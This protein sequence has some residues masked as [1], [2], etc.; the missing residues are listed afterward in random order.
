M[1][2]SNWAHSIFC[3]YPAVGFAFY[4][5]ISLVP[6]V[7]LAPALLDWGTALAPSAMANIFSWLI[8]LVGSAVWMAGVYGFSRLIEPWTYFWYLVNSWYFMARL[9][10]NEHP[11]ILARIEEFADTIVALDKQADDDEELVLVSHSCGTFLAVYIL[12]AVLRRNPDIAKR[13]GDSRL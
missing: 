6:L 3:L 11:E 8:L 7:L 10:R 2:K 13:A 1:F 12:A 4:C 5:A 9:A